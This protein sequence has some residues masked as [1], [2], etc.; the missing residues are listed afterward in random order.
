CWS[1]K[2]S[3]TARSTPALWNARFSASNRGLEI[4]EWVFYAQPRGSSGGRQTALSLNSSWASGCKLDLSLVFGYPQVFKSVVL[5]SRVM[6]E[7]SAL[8]GNSPFSRDS[9]AR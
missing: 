2:A 5:S 3:P 6:G 4:A 1:M 9:G 7:K 8:P